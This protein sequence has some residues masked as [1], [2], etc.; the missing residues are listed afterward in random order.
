MERKSRL[1]FSAISVFS[2][3]ILSEFPTF[4]HPQTG[5]TL[6]LKYF[7]YFCHYVFFFF[8]LIFSK[9]I[10]KLTRHGTEYV[11]KFKF[12]VFY[13]PWLYKVSR[14]KR[15]ILYNTR[16][17]KCKVMYPVT[18]STPN[19]TFFFVINLLHS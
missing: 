1:F 2:R 13:W 8:S 6:S 4:L 16:F 15:Y 14:I 9:T 7:C 3:K 5:Q 18:L 11:R 12:C 17:I 19:L 10:F